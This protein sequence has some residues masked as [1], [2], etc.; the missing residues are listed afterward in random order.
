MNLSKIKSLTI[1]EGK[2]ESI[3]IGG[4]TVWSAIVSSFILSDGSIL[5]TS[6]GNI[7]ITKQEN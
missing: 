1:P 2:V 4:V 7:F 6:D 5:T 3:S